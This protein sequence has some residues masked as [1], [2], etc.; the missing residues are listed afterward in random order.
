MGE[1]KAVGV[2][3]GE[4]CRGWAEDCMVNSELIAPSNDL[5]VRECARLQGV[6]LSIYSCSRQCCS[7]HSKM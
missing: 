7:G 5:E 6:E 2:D 1:T 4:V 3:L